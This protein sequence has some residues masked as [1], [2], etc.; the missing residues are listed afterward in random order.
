[1]EGIINEEQS[2]QLPEENIKAVL[3]SYQKK[4]KGEGKQNYIM[5][6]GKVVP[7]LT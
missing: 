6:L 3:L 7:G 2:L 5:R 1:M 4:I